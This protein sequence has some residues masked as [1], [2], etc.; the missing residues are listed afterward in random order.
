MYIH[1]YVYTY[2]YTYIYIYIYTHTHTYIG[3][4]GHRDGDREAQGP[5]EPLGCCLVADKGC[6][7]LTY[8]II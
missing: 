7:V 8:N 5:P 2:T 3:I 6:S 1:V 4:S